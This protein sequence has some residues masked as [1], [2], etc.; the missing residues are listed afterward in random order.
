MKKDLDQSSAPTFLNE[1]IEENTDNSEEAEKVKAAMEVSMKGFG[2]AM[3][4]TIK[5]IM[6][7]RPNGSG[8]K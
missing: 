5:E 1:V 4:D 7:G 8:R 3:N 6:E 2:A